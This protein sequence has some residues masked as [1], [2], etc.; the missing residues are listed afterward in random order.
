MN[1]HN[2]NNL[3]VASIVTAAL[4]AV[5][6]GLILALRLRA[7]LPQ[8]RSRAGARKAASSAA[9][10]FAPPR[11]SPSFLQDQDA[12]LNSKTSAT[13]RTLHSECTATIFLGSGGHT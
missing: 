4:I 9:D 5:P 13:D 6:L 3:L 11:T 12:D 10:F 8:H 2:V 1:V 7:A